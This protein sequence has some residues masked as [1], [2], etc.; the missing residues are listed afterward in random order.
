MNIQTKLPEICKD[1]HPDEGYFFGIGVFETMLYKNGEIELLPLHMKR[2]TESAAA[3]GIIPTVRAV[4]GQ[5]IKCPEHSAYIE[6]IEQQLSAFLAENAPIPDHTVVKLTW[7]SDR[8]YCSLRPNAYTEEQYEKGFHLELSP[9]LR[10]ETSLFTFHK[11]LNY[12]DNIL[13]K[14]RAHKDGFDEPIFLNSKGEVSEGATT[15]IF[16]VTEEGIF[17]PPV[18]SGLLNG[19]VR[20]HLLQG[21]FGIKEKVLYPQD[22]KQAK[23]IFVTNALLG[24]MPVCRFGERAFSEWKVTNVLKKQAGLH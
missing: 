13:E 4:N 22:L 23:E 16:I 8:L 21:E 19:T 3:L 6:Q 15:N 1:F 9:V 11:T 17:T 14:R 5:H 20:Q 18:S 12:G 7:S 10:N 2:I 24:I